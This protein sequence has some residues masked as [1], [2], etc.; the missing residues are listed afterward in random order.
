MSKLKTDEEMD[1][2]VDNMTHQRVVDENAELRGKLGAANERAKV[3][4]EKVTALDEQVKKREEE[5]AKVE[6]KLNRWRTW[7]K[8][9]LTELQQ[10]REQLV[11]ELHEKYKDVE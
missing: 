8:K 11:D 3:A 5:K 4:E 10:K 7:T 2:S 9:H 1:D 6:G